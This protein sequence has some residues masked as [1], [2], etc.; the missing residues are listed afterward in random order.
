MKS[1]FA[2]MAVSVLLL[3][4]S[5]ACADSKGRSS[6]NDSKAV[7]YVGGG[8]FWCTEAAY[9]ILDGVMDVESGYAGGTVKDP[10]YDQVCSGSTGHAEMVKITY[11]PAR[12]SYREILDWFFTIHD[13]TTLNRQG[14]DVGTQYRSVVFYTSEEEKR[15]ALDLIGEL[16]RG[17]VFNSVIVTE[18]VPLAD[19]WPAEGYHQDYFRKNPGAGYCR[20]V[21]AP[22]IRKLSEL[23]DD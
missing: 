19:Y 22:K 8:C 3:S 11:D 4:V 23:A 14:A 15:I 20:V 6:M 10:G 12:V 9:E 17:G 7:A 16:N 1:K 5:S 2:L 13:P 18:V 21:I